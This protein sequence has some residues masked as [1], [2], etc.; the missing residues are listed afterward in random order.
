MD[1]ISLL[2]DQNKVLDAR[3]RT[4]KHTYDLPKQNI[5]QLKT[6]NTVFKESNGVFRRK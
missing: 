5:E 1:A 4:L 2:N 3:H 6:S